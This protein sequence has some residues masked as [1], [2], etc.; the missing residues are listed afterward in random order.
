MTFYPGQPVCIGYTP[1]HRCPRARFARCSVGTILSGPF[2]ADEIRKASGRRFTRRDRAWLVDVDGRN[3]V[4]AE[5]LLSP[6]NPPGEAEQST[7]TKE[8]TV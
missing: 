4:V 2:S 1:D 5:R 6:Y 8:V 7:T 3:V